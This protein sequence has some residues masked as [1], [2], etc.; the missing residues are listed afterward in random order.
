LVVM[1][2]IKGRGKRLRWGHPVQRFKRETEEKRG[3]RGERGEDKIST[4][5]LEQWTFC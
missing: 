1:G 3:E 2:K 5:P 4:I